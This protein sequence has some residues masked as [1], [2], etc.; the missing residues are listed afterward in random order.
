MAAASGEGTTKPFD[1]KGNDGDEYLKMY[2]SDKQES[3]DA[4][5]KEFHGVTATEIMGEALDVLEKKEGLDRKDIKVL[6]VGCSTGGLLH[7]FESLG[8]K[9]ENLYGTDLSEPAI[10]IAKEAHPAYKLQV[11]LYEYALGFGEEYEIGN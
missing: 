10:K 5:Y 1:W 3:V 8:L 11:R 6:D 9:P 7:V 4:M 2:P